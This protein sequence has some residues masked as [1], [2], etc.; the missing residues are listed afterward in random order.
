MPEKSLSRQLSAT[1]NA[2]C[3]SRQS[4]RKRQSIL[5]AT[6]VAAVFPFAES[7]V[8]RKETAASSRQ[9][10]DSKKAATTK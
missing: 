7:P 1:N 9:N 2:G 3:Q 8:K 10:E 5:A 6:S 4:D